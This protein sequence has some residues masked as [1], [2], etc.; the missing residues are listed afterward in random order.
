MLM[1]KQLR[2]DLIVISVLSL[3][4]VACAG[5]QDDAELTDILTPDQLAEEI[6]KSG[7]PGEDL[8]EAPLD[9]DAQESESLA[10]GESSL[11]DNA[12]DGEVDGSAEPGEPIVA[13]QH[14]RPD[15]KPEDSSEDTNTIAKSKDDSIDQEQEHAQKRPK[16]REF[17]ID[18]NVPENIRVHALRNRMVVVV[19]KSLQRAFWIEKGKLTNQ[20]KISSGDKGYDTPIG[21]Y[22]ITR[23]H[24]RYVSKKYKARMDDAIFFFE[25][26]AIHATYGK[27]IKLLGP[28]S[29]KK[30]FGYSHG[31]V[32]QSP[33]DADDLFQRVK[34]HG[35]KNVNIVIQD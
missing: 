19:D 14:Q 24:A 5:N 30:G 17:E 35:A 6:Q 8:N 32:R 34:F 10:D 33:E 12:Q 26:Y 23:M 7:D 15:G 16:G 20:Y 29:D 21:V 13:D 25:G 4:L 2:K 3:V 22:P 11:I 27:N 31:C 18:S 9:P 1:L 28:R